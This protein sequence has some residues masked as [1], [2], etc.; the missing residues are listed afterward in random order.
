MPWVNRPA[1]GSARSRY[2][3]RDNARVKKRE[4]KRCSTACS[5]PPIYWSTGIQ[6]SAAS[7]SKATGARAEQ[8]RRKYQDESKK[9]S[10][11]SVSRRA[12]PLQVGQA[13]CFHVG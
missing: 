9:V 3:Q 1:N 5:T 10:S 12:G 8:K 2:P 11:V 4:Y 7:R 6:Y 13:T